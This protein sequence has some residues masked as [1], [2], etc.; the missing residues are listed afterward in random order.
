MGEGLWRRERW[1]TG[2]LT[3]CKKPDT[4]LFGA[5]VPQAT[6]RQGDRVVKQSVQGGVVFR[7][8]RSRLCSCCERGPK[9]KTPAN[10]MSVQHSSE[11]APRV[12][13]R[14]AFTEVTA[15]KEA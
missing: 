15:G 12:E 2:Q 10:R 1:G 8:D 4:E 6:R 14:L 5:I 7:E 13:R 11:R 9:T 3:S